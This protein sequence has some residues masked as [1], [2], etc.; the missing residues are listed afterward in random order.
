VC[1]Q[2]DASIAS[3]VLFS[4]FPVAEHDEI[5]ARQQFASSA[6]RDDPALGIDDLDLDMRQHPPHG[7]HAALDR[8]GGG[9]CETRRARLGHAIA[10]YDLGQMHQGDSSFHDLDGTRAAGH[11][12]GAQ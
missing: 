5:T 6:A 7:R 4:S 12:A 11:H 3:R 1:I 2:P 9:G 10:D 8:V